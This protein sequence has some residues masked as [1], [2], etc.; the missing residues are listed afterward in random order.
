MP[1]MEFAPDGSLRPVANKRD[2]GTSWNRKRDRIIKEQSYCFLCGD[3]VDKDLPGNDPMG[4]SVDHL[5]P[6]SKGGSDDPEN[7]YLSHLSCNK[8]RG[9]KPVDEVRYTP[10]SRVW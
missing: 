3:L 4:P 9:N 2:R 8:R 5:I 10:Q 1:S 7:L 6:V